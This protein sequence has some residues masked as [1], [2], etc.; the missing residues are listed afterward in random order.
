MKTPYFLRLAEIDNRHFITACRHG[1]VHLTWDRTTVRFTR[2]EFRRLASLVEHATVAS[3][4]ASI[5]D[6]ELAVTLRPEGRYELRVGP[7]VLFLSPSQFEKLVPATQQ[8]IRRLD[9]ILASGTWDGEDQ[10]EAPPS[11][12]DQLQRHPFSDN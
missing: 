2:D 12:L 5:R 7:L 3:P 4:P 6:G 1:L 9:E 8:A 11:I 10:D